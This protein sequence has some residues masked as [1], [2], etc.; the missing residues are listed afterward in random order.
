ME[1]LHCPVKDTAFFIPLTRKYG[2]ILKGAA[3]EI[4]VLSRLNREC[5]Y[6][7][8]CRDINIDLDIFC[9]PNMN[10]R[11]SAVRVTEMSLN[12]LQSVMWYFISGTVQTCTFSICLNP[13]LVCGYVFSIYCTRYLI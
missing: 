3:H 7:R 6:G 1:Q 9:T 11:P 13:V 4:R 12:K 2:F 10:I 5:L 8:V